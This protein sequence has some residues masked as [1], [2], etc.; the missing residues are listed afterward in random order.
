[1]AAVAV[2]IAPPGST[3]AMLQGIEATNQ[4]WPISPR[5]VIR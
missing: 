2:G 3:G 5:T 4:A 1:M